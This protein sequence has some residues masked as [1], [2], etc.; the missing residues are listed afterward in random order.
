MFFGR[1]NQ[2]MT[3]FQRSARFKYQSITS[4]HTSGA[5]CAFFEGESSSQHPFVVL[6]FATVPVGGSQS[7]PLLRGGGFDAGEYFDVPD[8]TT[9][10]I[11]L[12]T[13]IGEADVAGFGLSEVH[14]RTACQMVVPFIGKDIPAFSIGGSFNQI[15]IELRTVFK[16]CPDGLYRL[17]TSQVYFNPFLSHAAWTPQGSVVIIYGIFGTE[18]IVIRG[19]GA[20][21]LAKGEVG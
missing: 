5:G 13:G 20:N 8:G 2:R 7:E 10:T 21:A 3:E 1:R 4:V 18:I 6:P 12:S 11:L 9:E 14:H 19:R 15:L 17:A 16:L